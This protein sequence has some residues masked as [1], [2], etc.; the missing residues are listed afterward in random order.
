M[1]R[2]LSKNDFNRIVRYVKGIPGIKMQSVSENMDIFVSE[3]ENLR[4][5]ILS[6]HAIS[7][8][9]KSNTLANLNPATYNLIKKI[10]NKKLIFLITICV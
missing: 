3:E 8:Y 2:Q 6:S 4:Y 1:D 9:C 10:P 7:Q 5:S